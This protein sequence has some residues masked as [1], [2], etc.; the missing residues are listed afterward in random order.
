MATVEARAEDLE[1]GY[2]AV[3]YR[4]GGELWAL[5]GIVGVERLDVDGE[6]LALGSIVDE[7]V[8]DDPTCPACAGTGHTCEVHARPWD[9]GPGDTPPGA[10]DCGAP[11][12]PCPYAKGARP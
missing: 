7:F 12:M 9:P 4:L 3:S 5:E 6:D 1:S 11:G 8:H 2:V 10:C